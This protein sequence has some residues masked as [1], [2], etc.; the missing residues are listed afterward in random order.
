M[1]G[2]IL[3]ELKRCLISFAFVDN[4]HAMAEDERM[5]RW[6]QKKSEDCRRRHGTSLEEVVLRGEPTDVILVHPNYPEQVRLI[7]TLDGYPW[8]VVYEPARDR[9]ANA[10]PSRKFKNIKELKDGKKK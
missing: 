7:Y 4:V 10:W 5:A 3:D 9:F 1:S 6:D 2:R 8:V